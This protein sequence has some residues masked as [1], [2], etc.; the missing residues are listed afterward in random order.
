MNRMLLL[1]L[2]KSV[3]F[4]DP[5]SVDN[6]HAFQALSRFL[7]ARACIF[8]FIRV[9]SLFKMTNST[10]NFKRIDQTDVMRKEK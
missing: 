8:I 1:Y 7:H 4:K 3:L 6:D 5:K 10:R 2:K 9:F